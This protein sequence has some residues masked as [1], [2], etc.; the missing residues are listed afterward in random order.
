MKPFQS[1]ITAAF[2][3]LLSCSATA[4]NN[5]NDETA[6]KKVLQ[7]ETS[8]FFHKDYNGWAACWLHDTAASVLRAGASGYDQLL[9]WNAITA[10]YKS[11]I[12]SLDVRSE[13][14]IEPFL[15]KTDYHIYING[16]MAAISFKE[17][18]KTPNTEMRTLVKHNGAWKILNFTL[19]N[20]AGYEMMD[21]MNNI[22]SF[23]GK[24]ELD[25]KATR[26]PSD[27]G[28]LNSVKFDLRETPGG[29]EQ[30]S[31]GIFTRNNI[32]YAPP[33]EHE[34]FIPDYGTNT[35][36]YMD[37]S[38]NQSGQTFTQTGKVTSVSPNSFTVTIMYPDKP[39]AI[40]SEYTVTMPN[41][42]WHQVGKRYDRDGKQNITT[43]IDLKRVVQ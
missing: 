18:D 29:L 1:A 23:V 34:Y 10:A 28:V 3:L 40:Q 9:G 39:A 16:N 43:T 6:I 5:K 7:Q 35:V 24:W 2:L 22:K 14:E 19:L 17:G 15:N 36:S 27:G 38:K 25:G 20:N 33:A 11:D 4:Q 31:N 21:I 32:S 8:T 42:K 13:A 37:I 30:I 26:E 41:G 12:Q